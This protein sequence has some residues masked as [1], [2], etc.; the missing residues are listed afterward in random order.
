M[1]NKIV[2]MVYALVM[3]CAQAHDSLDQR[4]YV[5]FDI[6]M[7][8]ALY[9]KKLDMKWGKPLLDTFRALYQRNNLMNVT[10]AVVPKIPKIIHQIWIG[11]PVPEKYTELVNTWKKY[12][13][14]WEYQLW[15]DKEVEELIERGDFFTSDALQYYRE[16]INYGEKSDILKYLLIYRFGGLYTDIS[17]FECLRSF[18]VLHHCYDFYVGIAPLDT[19]GVQIAAGLFAAAAGHPILKACIDTLKD[20]HGNGG[21]VAK[22]GPVHFTRAFA[23]V[24]PTCEGTVVAFPASYFYPRGYTQSYETRSEWLCAESFAVHHWAGSW[25]EDAGFTKK[26]SSSDWQKWYAGCCSVIEHWSKPLVV[27]SDEFR[28]ENCGLWWERCLGKTVSLPQFAQWLGGVDAESRCA[29]RRHVQRKGYRSLLDIPSG[30]CIDYFGLQRDGIKI[31]YYGVDIASQLVEQS[32]RN[33]INVT[34]GSIEHIPYSDRAFDIVYARHILEHLDYYEKALAEMMRVAQ[35][36][37]MVVFFIK[38]T[39]SSEDQMKYEELCGH[40][41]FNNCYAREKLEKYIFSHPRV[42]NVV[43]EPVGATEEIAHIYLY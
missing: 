34:R 41:V 9:P 11:S 14:D 29:M 5:D 18:D 42:K 13:P 27:K 28:G 7:K 33:G 15:T 12:H 17:D 38:P 22:T 3:L 31:D 6:S 35:K 25:T 10:Y 21:V 32:V 4:I 43:W 39:T 23:L 36:E 20:D 37:V 24:A 1:N 26:M 19:A 16:A 8:T 2:M 30:V 40:Y